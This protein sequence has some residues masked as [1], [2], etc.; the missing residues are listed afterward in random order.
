MCHGTS[1]VVGCGQY[2]RVHHRVLEIVIRPELSCS[3]VRSMRE[4]S[5]VYRPNYTGVPDPYYDYIC[6][7]TGSENID[8]SNGYTES[9]GS[10]NFN[11]PGGQV[12]WV[13]VRQQHKK[14]AQ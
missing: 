5:R 11:I 7:S 9:A 4:P 1:D 3:N 6:R 13:T 14:D 2:T 8:K 10:E 12:W